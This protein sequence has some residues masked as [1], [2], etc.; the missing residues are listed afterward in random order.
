MT[1]LLTRFAI[2]E[3]NTYK[4]KTNTAPP[5][6]VRRSVPGDFHVASFHVSIQP[7]D[8]GLYTDEL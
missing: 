4:A 6:W 8:A 3:A 2:H 5:D 7:E 1:H